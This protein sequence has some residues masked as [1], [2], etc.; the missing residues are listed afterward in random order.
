M[1]DRLLKEAAAHSKFLSDYDVPSYAEAMKHF[2]R[3]VVPADLECHRMP[4]EALCEDCDKYA[5]LSCRRDKHNSK[6]RFIHYYCSEHAPEDAKYFVLEK[7]RH[8]YE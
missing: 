7:A 3:K 2:D 6:G 4:G 1:N 8:K 5:L